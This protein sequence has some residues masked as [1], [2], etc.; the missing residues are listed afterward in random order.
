MVNVGWAIVA[1]SVYLAFA[2]TFTGLDEMWWVV[3][4]LA[5]LGMLVAVTLPE[6]V[7]RD[8]I[9]ERQRWVDSRSAR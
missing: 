5:L 8:L 7:P 3:A 9:M 2:A 6:P 1:L 4:G